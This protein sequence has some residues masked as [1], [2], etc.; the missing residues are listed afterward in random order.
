MIC[1]SSS[2]SKITASSVASEF[3]VSFIGSPNSLICKLIASCSSDLELHS[4]TIFRARDF[5]GV[6]RFQSRF[7]Q[8]KAFRDYSKYHIT[9]YL[10]QLTGSLRNSAESRLDL[11][12]FTFIHPFD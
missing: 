4:V 2:I 6:Y 1:S 7:C 8:H 5:K 11:H 3:D 12:I 9:T 10:F